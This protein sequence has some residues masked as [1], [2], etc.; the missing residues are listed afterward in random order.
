MS[1]ATVKGIEINID[2][3]QYVPH[4]ILADSRALRQIIINLMSNAIKFT[5]KGSITIKV[6]CLEVSVDIAKLVISLQIKPK[7]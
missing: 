4:M 1:Q 5:D 7:F 6:A 2:Y 3:D